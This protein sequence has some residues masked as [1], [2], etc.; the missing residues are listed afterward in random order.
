MW[1]FCCNKMFDNWYKFRLIY[2]LNLS[3]RAIAARFGVD[4]EATLKNILFARAFTLEHQMELIIEFAARF[5]EKKELTDYWYKIKFV[6]I[7]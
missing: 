5:D 6:I 3:P 1:A 7:S 2:Y 4:Q